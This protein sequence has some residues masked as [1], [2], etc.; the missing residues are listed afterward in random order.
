MFCH[1]QQKP[2]PTDSEVQLRKTLNRQH[3]KDIMEY[4]K[5]IHAKEREIGDLKRKISKV[6][7]K[8]QS[9]LNIHYCSYMYM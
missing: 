2:T 9:Q 1:M 7:E 3:A 6:G 4:T 5:Q 8:V